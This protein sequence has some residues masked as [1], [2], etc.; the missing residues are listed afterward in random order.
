MFALNM[1]YVMG[2]NTEFSAIKYLAQLQYSQR[3]IWWTLTKALSTFLS[4]LN[5]AELM[6]SSQKHLHRNIYASLNYDPRWVILGYFSNIYLSSVNLKHSFQVLLM[7]I[8]YVKTGGCLILHYY[9]SF[10]Q[11]LQNFH[12]CT[13]TLAAL[14]NTYGLYLFASEILFHHQYEGCVSWRWATWHEPVEQTCS[15]RC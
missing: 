8:H 15:F 1:V 5:I 11:S 9:S 13:F 14:K 12:I 6:F 3:G 4:V 2:K 10:L 7:L